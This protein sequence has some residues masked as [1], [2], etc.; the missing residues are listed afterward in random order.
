MLY[1]QIRYTFTVVP[2]KLVQANLVHQPAGKDEWES[3]QAE[4]GLVYSV[5][6]E[7]TSECCRSRL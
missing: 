4:A 6:K 1:T 7:R 2:I 5:G 3:K